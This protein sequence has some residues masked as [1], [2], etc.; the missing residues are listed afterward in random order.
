ME[1]AVQRRG[2][3]L[4][5]ALYG[6]GVVLVYVG[7]RVV[8]AGSARAAS[9]VGAALIATV[10]GVRLWRAARASDEERG[11]E[12]IFAALYGVALGALA[13][14]FA[15]SD[16]TTGML[17]KPLATGYPRLAGVLG[18]LWP[19]LLVGSLIP[20][21]LVELAWV[22]VARAPRL[23]IG[24]L[25]D[26]LYSG[27]GLAGALVFAF[28]VAY[29]ASE[30]DA[31]VDLSYFRTAKPGE[32]THKIIA[33]LDQPVQVAM[34]F[35]P[36]NE[37]REQVADYF[38]DLVKDSKLLEVHNY[39]HAVDPAK[40]KELGVSGNGTVVLQRAGR[41]E[42]LSVGTDLEGARTQL[43]NLDKEVQKRLILVARPARTVYLT[44]GHGERAFDPAGENDKRPTVR[45]LRELLQQQGYTVRTLGAA[46]G[47]GAE[48]PGDAAIVLVLGPDKPLA[49]EET[50]SIERYL[51]KGGRLLV[52]LD[53]ENAVDGKD[54][55]A[56]L[57]LVWRKT[58]LANDQVYARR[59]YQANDRSNIATGSF[60]SH[61]SVT[62]LGRLGM[63]APMVL[64]GAGA[65]EELPAKEK[66]KDVSI[67]FT[68]RSHPATWNDLNG[69]FAFDAPAE[70]R[71]GWQ[72]AAAV[73]RKNPP[74][75]G[76]PDAK[77]EARAIVI[78]DSDAFVDGVLG[79]P[80]NAYFALD[81]LRWLAGD[82]SISGTI[83]SE[84]DV[85]IAH[86]HK[87]DVFW[88]YSSIFVAPALALGA[89]SLA[90]RRR[91]AARKEPQ[92]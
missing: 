54:L 43:A 92:S 52:A 22:A 37:V 3:S 89:G 28:T 24:R 87:Q 21:L 68:V 78:A 73:T 65:L 31:K 64:L 7:E 25:R 41:K 10:A 82:E 91:R 14:Y 19:A 32:S 33:S 23:E 9:G 18:A 17:S 83:S 2:G 66:P 13:I 80:G 20:V 47:L 77:N 74:A 55:L 59:S 29:V 16:L 46:D 42:L 15:Q 35:P 81:G 58:L 79:N 6:V 84:V 36:A 67:D 63:R 26:A 61:P 44:T 40:A 38:A 71:K 70:T 5:S 76:K 51:Q 56:P 50:A 11:V 27:I 85:P 34:F 39:D 60:S 30:R 72:L 53:P 8:G 48:V 88:F 62:S 12:R 57:G 1:V 75:D 86:T 90:T 4:W 49:A 45:D 69:N